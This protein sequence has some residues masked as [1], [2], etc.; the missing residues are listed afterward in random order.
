MV[1]KRPPN[2]RNMLVRADLPPP[3]PTHFLSTV[4]SGNY[5]CGHCQQCH[6]THKTKQFNHP[7]T[8]KK[9]N[10]KG[11]ISCSTTNVIYMLKCPC[12]LAYIGKTTRSLKTRIAEHR[13]AIR[14][15]VATSSVAV[16]FSAANHNVST[17]KYIRIETIK[18]LRRGG[19]INSL[20]LKRELYWIHTLNTLAPK[21]LNEDFDIRP[22]L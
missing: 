9:Y 13:S 3:A 22:F 2:L 8:G 16:H 6:F 14:N 19:D 15:N 12:G 20:L 17:L 4:P 1:Y 7:H 18:P 21:G 11:I 10:I 5:P